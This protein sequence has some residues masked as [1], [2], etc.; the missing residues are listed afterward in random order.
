MPKCY[1][2]LMEEKFFAK[3]FAGALELAQEIISAVAKDLE[4]VAF[5]YDPTDLPLVCAAM[6]SVLAA[7]EQ[8]I[9]PIGVALADQI[10]E[11]TEVVSFESDDRIEEPPTSV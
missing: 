8:H 1:I 2:D 11:M 5:A 9:G 4:E 6:K 7:M 10:T 3:D